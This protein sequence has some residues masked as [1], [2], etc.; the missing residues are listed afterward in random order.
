MPKFQCS[1]PQS[2]SSSSFWAD[3][4]VQHYC[5]CHVVWCTLPLLPLF[6]H[7]LCIWYPLSLSLSLLFALICRLAQQGLKFAIIM[8]S[9]MEIVRL[10]HPLNHFNYCSWSPAIFWWP[11]IQLPFFF[12]CINCL[13]WMLGN[14]KKWNFILISFSWWNWKYELLFFVMLLFNSWI[15]MRCWQLLVSCFVWFL[16]L[17]IFSICCST[18]KTFFGF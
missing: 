11:F 6:S 10:L 17:F 2:A 5:W 1:P 7:C 12:R 4:A 3:R 13:F 15:M 8:Y 14:M 16:F 9:Y 18:R